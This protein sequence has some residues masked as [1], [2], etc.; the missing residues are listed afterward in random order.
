[1]SKLKINSGLLSLVLVACLFTGWGTML[2]VA[3]LVLIFCEMD[4]KTKN[5]FVRVVSF[6]A[7]ITLFNLF[8]DLIT[9]AVSLGIGSIKDLIAVINSYLDYGKQISLGD[10]DRY[11][12]VP[13]QGL[14]DIADSIVYYI[15][16][17]VEFKFIVGLFL[18]RPGK[19]NFIIKKIE[20]YVNSVINFVNS[21]EFGAG[22]QQPQQP[23][24]PQP[25]YNGQ[26]PMNPM[27]QPTGMQQ[28]QNF[29]QP[30]M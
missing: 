29:N 3:A 24:Q 11:L 5:I 26:Q 17:L 15:I 10:L 22:F 4:D 1:M 27:G 21:F 28:P 2:T 19:P 18:N 30:N 23:V 25:M 13:A 6:F 16:S 8:W 20:G 9:G 12:L 7:A 14:V